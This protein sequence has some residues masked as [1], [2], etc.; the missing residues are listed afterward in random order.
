MSDETSLYETTRAL[1]GS[2]CGCRTCIDAEPNA[3]GLT[4]LPNS[5]SVLVVCVECGNKRCPKAQH[6]DHECSGSNEV[7]QVG[8]GGYGEPCECHP[9]PEGETLPPPA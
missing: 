9:L 5:A 6:H 1:V 4:S 2:E 8:A 7:G 3:F